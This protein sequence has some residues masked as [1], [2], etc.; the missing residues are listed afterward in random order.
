MKNFLSHWLFRCVLAFLF[1]Y[2][3]GAFVQW[4]FDMS[5]WSDGDRGFLLFCAFPACLF[6]NIDNLINEASR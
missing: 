4:S 1:V 5:G 2:L 3:A 6:F